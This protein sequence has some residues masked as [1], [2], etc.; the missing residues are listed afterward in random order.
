MFWK[1]LK[2]LQ[3]GL[4]QGFHQFINQGL[5]GLYIFIN[6]LE[7]YWLIYNF[8]LPTYVFDQIVKH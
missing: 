7:E 3:N 2:N 6:E 1:Y 4:F 5:E 8:T